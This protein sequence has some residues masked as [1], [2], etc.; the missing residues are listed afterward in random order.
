MP[1]IKPN[2][3]SLIM[4]R[5]AVNDVN[6]L[7]LADQSGTKPDKQ[8]IQQRDIAWKKAAEE[9]PAFSEKIKELDN[10]TKKT[11][12]KKE[13]YP[14]ITKYTKLFF[15]HVE[16]DTAKNF[17]EDVLCF[18]IDPSSDLMET[19]YKEAQDMINEMGNYCRLC[20]APIK[21]LTL[22]TI[23]SSIMEGKLKLTSQTNQRA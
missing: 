1:E 19:G 20:D 17:L 18:R 11:T 5:K 10:V 14:D 6:K 22:K 4:L 9:N 12:E 23:I 8:S 13:K 16:E 15:G 21:K 2:H 3:E 7:Y